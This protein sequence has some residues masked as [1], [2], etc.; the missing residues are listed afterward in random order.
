MTQKLSEMKSQKRS[1]TLYFMNSCAEEVW[2][3]DK[4]VWSNGNK[5]E[6]T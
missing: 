5:P 1:E 6:G 3:E 2:L 4:S